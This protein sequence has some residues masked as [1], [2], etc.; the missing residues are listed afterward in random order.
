MRFGLKVRVVAVQP[1]DAAMGFEVRLLQNASDTRPTHGPEATLKQSGH[2]VVQT[3]ACGGTV[4]R[5]RFT[6]GHRH[7]I[8]TF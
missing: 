3:P 4:V 2:Q 6:R 1:I 5:G 7:H 8:Q